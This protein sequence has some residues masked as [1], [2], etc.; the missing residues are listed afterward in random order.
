MNSNK[1]YIFKNIYGNMYEFYINKDNTLMCN[2]ISE[3]TKILE[4]V[5]KFNINIT[6]LGIIEVVCITFDGSIKYCK[7]NKKWSVQT[8]YKLKSHNNSIDEVN[9]FSKGDKL[10][11][12]FMFYENRYDSRGNILHYVWNG[13]KFETNII[14]P[15]NTIDGVERHYYLETLDNTINM[16]YITKERNSNV[17]N[18]CKYLDNDDWSSP[19]KLYRLNGNNINF[20]T[21]K[22]DKEF[23]I[24]NLSEE[25]GIYALEHVTINTKDNINNFPIYKTNNPIYEST[26]I[27]FNDI[28]YC[29]WSE[30]NKLMYSSFN[31]IKWSNSS[32]IDTESFDN[33]GMYKYIYEESPLDKSIESKNIFASISDNVNIFL[34]KVTKTYNNK[35]NDKYD[36]ESTIRKLLQ[37]V[38]KKN[39][40]NYDLM[41]KTILL[42]E[43]LKEKN[44]HV[45][46]LIEN[47]NKV[48]IQKSNIESKHKS[49]LEA[50]DKLK[51]QTENFKRKLNKES[52]KNEL[53]EIRLK[54]KIDENE[55]LNNIIERLEN[56]NITAVKNL[57]NKYLIKIKA[58][59]KQLEDKQNELKVL[60]DKNKNLQENIKELKLENDNTKEQLEKSRNNTLSNLRNKYDMEVSTIKQQ[61]E[62]KE[63]SFKYITDYSQKLEATLDELKSENSIIK[64]QLENSKNKNFIEKIFGKSY[65]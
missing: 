31:S 7:F 54:E 55:N 18:L 60:L 41:N 30:H 13:S 23:N 59:K 52:E 2:E 10:H 56:Q 14:A 25:N 17:I 53:L 27:I 48:S 9:L 61:L 15:I 64:Q 51:I 47:L 20:S 45:N 43:K 29:V 5:S 3:E 42:T 58:I 19:K 6:Y 38:S 12:F 4:N 16:F 37:E 50:N 24:L 28:L 63:K 33:I 57:E 40:V 44:I 22:R 36:A 46:N 34:P 35:S 62:E 21:L 49:I 32:E 1:S 26:F 8:L 65:K 39:T 11:I